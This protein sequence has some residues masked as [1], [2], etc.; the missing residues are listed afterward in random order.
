MQRL[1]V[2][3]STWKQPASSCSDASWGQTSPQESSSLNTPLEPLGK[4]LFIH[5]CP[6]RGH[7]LWEAFLR[8]DE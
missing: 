7:L 1:H 5:Q 3:R 8:Q 2:C 6:L 4:L